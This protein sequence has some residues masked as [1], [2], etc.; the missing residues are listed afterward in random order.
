MW[1]GRLVLAH[2]LALAD[3]MLA[4][5]A[6]AEKPL[7]QIAKVQVDGRAFPG[8]PGTNA[9]PVKRLIL[10]P[11]PGRVDFNYW[12][13]DEAVE[14]PLRLRYKLE[15]LEHQ[16]LS[17][18]AWWD[19][20]V[21]VQDASNHVLSFN[22]VSIT[23]CSKGWNCALD[24]SEFQ[25]RR[26]SI[27][28]PEGA[29]ELQVLLLSVDLSVLG[30]I[31]IADFQV[32]RANAAGR[33]ENIWPDST[34]EEGENLD[35]PNGR[36]RYWQRGGFGAR[37]AQ[38]FRLPPPA[39]GHALA[40]LDDDIHSSAS[41][42]AEL[43]LKNKA[44][45]GDTL[46]FEWREAFSVGISGQHHTPYY[47]LP[48]GD[49]VFH[50]ATDTPLGEPIGPEVAM[51][52]SIPQVFW[53]RPSVLALTFVLSAGG[54]VA[55]VRRVSRRRLQAALDHLE[56]EH[57]L[58]RERARIAQDLHDDLG[59][60]LTRINLLSQSTLGKIEPAHP[61]WQDAD[62]IR[63]EAVNVT[64]ALDEVVWAVAP[65]HDTLESLL[66]YLT[67]FV[68]EFLGPS[69]IRARIHAPQPLPKW[70]LPSELRHNV[71]LAAKSALNNVVKHARATEVHLRLEP[72][73]T[74]F[75]L[76]IEDNGCGFVQTTG[77]APHSGRPAR[78]GLAGMKARIESLGGHFF[79]DS[80]PG[81]GTRVTF[82]VPV[83]GVEP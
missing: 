62:G 6:E 45:A 59:A 37:M 55:I 30:A 65:R 16:W 75:K 12:P 71:F 57:R 64:K 69:G 46:T 82:T 25:T 17:P 38:V 34:L 19:L 51:T 23:G 1:C 53:K 73:T 11:H 8:S 13:A 22:R 5:P 74:A 33:V 36:P 48:P 26:A 20:L 18:L 15:P 78:H 3:V 54:A 60:T 7:C 50:V 32:L 31:A 29:E 49:Y 39:K 61:A 2:C 41:W 80:A 4:A 44:L 81:R 28:L 21:I 47:W 42:Q 56:H 58:N 68:G 79:L 63:S 14:R 83:P 35:Q 66:N 77:A 40:I 43:P 67:D 72:Q 27:T 76:V 52:I 70:M 24:R 10:P 9:A